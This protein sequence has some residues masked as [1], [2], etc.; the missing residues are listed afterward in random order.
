MV[1]RRLLMTLTLQLSPELQQRLEAG[2]QLQGKPPDAYALELLDESLS[3]AEKRRQAV[4]LLRSWRDPAKAAEQ[5]ET[6]DYL[7]KAL[8]EDRTSD[9]PFFPPELK[10]VSW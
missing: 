3:A 4:A 6:G 2:A 9:R 1:L 5:Q 10:G 7:I 8:D